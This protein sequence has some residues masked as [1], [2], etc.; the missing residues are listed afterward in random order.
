MTDQNEQYVAVATGTTN[1]TPGSTVVVDVADL[2]LSW[3]IQDNTFGDKLPIIPR[4][5]HVDHGKVLC[6][7]MIKV[8]LRSRSSA[9]P[10]AGRSITVKSNRTEDTVTV[11]PAST[12]ADGTALVKLESRKS[13]ELTLSITDHDV[14]AVPLSINLGEAWYEAG[15][16]ITHYVIADEHDA[17]G[18]MVQDPNVMGQH[19]RDFLYGARGVPMQGT[20]QTLDNHYVRFDG[21]GGGWHHNAAGHPDVLNHPETAHLRS[22]DAA[23]G[24]FADVVQ[25]HSIAVDPRVVPGRA[26]VSIASSDGTRV[27]GER[28]ADDTG[29]G[30]RGYHIDHFSGAG[31][32]ATARWEAAGGD[33]QNAKVKFLGY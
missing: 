1:T 22:T 19:R 33:M 8:T 15:F 12:G 7:L 29:G 21:G 23:H 5:S 24:A 32:A 17:N 26:R 18:P 28:H 4:E 10:V 27:V 6:R 20:G 13:G 25:D 3:E 14:S 16:Q 9:G 11:T 31:S 30:I 2:T